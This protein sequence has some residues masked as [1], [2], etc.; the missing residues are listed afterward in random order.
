MKIILKPSGILWL[1]VL[2]Y[3]SPASTASFLAAIALHELGHITALYLL[4]KKPDSMT[5]SVTGCTIRAYGLSYR[6]E[7]CAAAAGPIMSMLGG[8]FYP[9]FPEFAVISLLLAGFNLLPM[10]G[11]DG[12]RILSCLLSLKAPQ[13]G[14][15]M[16]RISRITLISVLAVALFFARIFPSQKIFPVIAA[17]FLA[18][19]LLLIVSP[20]SL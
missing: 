14:P 11:L 4:G 6:E 15:P 12:G 7:L 10:E 2:F 8:L 16:G 20:E 13:K 17:V 3:L 18:K 5:I 19:A 9:R 1:S